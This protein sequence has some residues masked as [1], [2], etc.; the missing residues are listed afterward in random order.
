ML[1][2]AVGLPLAFAAAADD[3]A[4]ADDELFG[5]ATAIDM[6]A[7]LD[8]CVMDGDDPPDDDDDVD[9]APAE[10]DEAALTAETEDGSTGQA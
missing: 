3:D 8:V 4:D 7:P 10:E 9:E 5:G 2:G 6:G 1:R